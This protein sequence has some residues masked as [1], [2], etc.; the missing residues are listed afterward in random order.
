[1][2]IESEGYQKLAET[3]AEGNSVVC[4]YKEELKKAL[5]LMFAMEYE[6]RKVEALC[7]LVGPKGSI[8]PPP[9]H[10]DVSKI[11]RK[12]KNWK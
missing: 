4:V 8:N 5:K 1:M 9:L 11:L 6:L 7:E 12:V 10:K 3:V 2:M